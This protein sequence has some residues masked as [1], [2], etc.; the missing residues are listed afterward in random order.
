M[1]QKN[2]LNIFFRISKHSI[3]FEECTTVDVFLKSKLGKQGKHGNL[4]FEVRMTI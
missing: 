3:L 4:I 2:N 1:F